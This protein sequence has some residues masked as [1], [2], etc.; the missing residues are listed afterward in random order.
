[1][2]PSIFS[3]RFMLRWVFTVWAYAAIEGVSKATV[4]NTFADKIDYSMSRILS[5]LI[6][7]TVSFL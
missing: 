4:N 1:M 6:R 5:H 2:F 7:P 3:K